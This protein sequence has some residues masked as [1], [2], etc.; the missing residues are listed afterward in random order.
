M[1]STHEMRMIQADASGLEQ[2]ACSTCGRRIQLRWPPD[3][4]KRVLD[5]GDQAACHVGATADAPQPPDAPPGPGQAL[6]SRRL[7]ETGIADVA[8]P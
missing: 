4:E 2:W 7:R 3:Y 1:Y 6:R 8:T 5:P